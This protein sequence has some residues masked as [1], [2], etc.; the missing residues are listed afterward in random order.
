M[1]NIPSSERH[2]PYSKPCPIATATSSTAG[3]VKRIGRAWTSTLLDIFNVTVLKELGVPR[4]ADFYLCGP[5][6]FLHDLTSGLAAWGVTR[7]QVH[8]EIFGP[9]PSSTP[10][11]VD[12]APSQPPHPP[13]GPPGTGSLV[14]FA[15]SGLSVH[16]DPAFHS[17][18]ELA[19][20]C[21][22]PV[23]W[24]CRTGVCHSCESGLI[25]GSVAY[26]P[27]PLERPAEGTVLICCSQPR[28]E[29][30]LDL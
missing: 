30:M 20:A 25:E 23:R 2:A 4:E 1:K 16:W 14:S 9:T 18:L 7:E 29:I 12:T 8:A 19:E 24:S 6:A 3:Q 5:A 28:E 22:V 10:G 21:D 27:E 11:L 26:Q 15:R 13:A 17:L